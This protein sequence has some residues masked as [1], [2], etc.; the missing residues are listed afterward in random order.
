MTLSWTL[1]RYLAMQFLISV[2]LVFGLCVTLGFVIDIVELLNRTAGKEAVPLA[3]IIGMALLKLPNLTE[4]MMPFAILFGAI[5]NFARLTRSQELVVARA[6]GVSAWLFLAPALVMSFVV[7]VFMTTVYNP[8]AARL[9]SRYEELEARYIRGRSSLLAVSTNGLWLRQGDE[10]GQTV[11][12]ALRVSNSGLRLQDVIMFIYEGKDLFRGRIDARAAALQRDKW[13]LERAWVTGP[14]RP[15]VFYPTLDV[16]T[17]LTPDKIQESFATPDTIAFWDLPQFI[18]QAEA[19]G[20]SATK[21]RLHYHALLAG[22]ALLCAM[23][24]VAAAFS[25]RLARLGGAARLILSGVLTGF[26]L[27]FFTDVTHALGISGIVPVALAAWAPATTALLLGM[28]SLFN[29][30]DG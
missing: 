6:S 20:F 12:H 19:A 9:V 10:K 26:L 21:H 25:L 5:W 14:D 15:A 17:S 11:I 22:P 16:K 30:E 4:K 18:S 24:F 2:G 29:Q 3:S 28:A 1:S 27:Y 8:F 13:H 7:G 23:I